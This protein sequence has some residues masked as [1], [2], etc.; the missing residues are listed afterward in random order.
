MPRIGL[1]VSRAEIDALF[2]SWDPDGSGALELAELN[3]QLRRGQEVQ[4]DAALQVLL[5]LSRPPFKVGASAPP[6]RCSSPPRRGAALQEGAQGVIATEAKN[7]HTIARQASRGEQR[8][9]AGQANAREAM[10]AEPRP[11]P[12]AGVVMAGASSLRTD[13]LGVP[14]RSTAHPHNIH[15]HSTI[16]LLQYRPVN[17]LDSGAKRRQVL[18][19]PLPTSREPPGAFARAPL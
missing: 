4:L 18:T 7:K 9:K 17:H 5:P 10:A 6:C 11:A 12:A 1:D 3:R 19:P 2:D 8:M 16:T 15:N 13:H 14:N